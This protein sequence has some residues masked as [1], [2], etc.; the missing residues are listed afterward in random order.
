MKGDRCVLD[1]SIAVAW[2][3]ED[4]K[5]SYT[6]HLLQALTQGMK[7]CVP[8][9]WPF[10]VANAL[11][12]AERRKRMTLAQSMYFFAR[13]MGLGI[14]INVQSSTFPSMDRALSQARKWNLTVYDAA[15]LELAL[16]EG[17]PLATLDGPLKN[18]ALSAGLPA[19]G[20][21]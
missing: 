14:S 12:V 16:R 1:A 19:L 3:F 10:E 21:Y 20:K 6:E 4:E 9:L 7:V 11:L 2:C 17:I 8:A 5:T 15:Y 13:L 18:A